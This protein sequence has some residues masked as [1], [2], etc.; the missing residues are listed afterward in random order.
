MLLIGKEVS[1]SICQTLNSICEFVYIISFYQ[2][3]SIAQGIFT[4]GI[5]AFGAVWGVGKISVI[6]KRIAR[7]ILLNCPGYSHAADT[8]IKDADH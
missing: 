8:G 5:R 7:T 6:E 4:Y 2:E 1:V 3:F